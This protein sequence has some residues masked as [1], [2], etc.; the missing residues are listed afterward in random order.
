MTEVIPLRLGT[1]NAYLLRGEDGSV[2]VDAG[3]PG[4]E[5]RLESGLRQAGVQPAQ[6]R[7]LLLTHGHFDHAGAAAYFQRLGVP[8][9]L[10]SADA[11]AM[12]PMTGKG[13]MGKL[14]LAVSGKLG[15]NSGLPAAVKLESLQSLETYGVEAAIVPLPGHTAG[16]VGVLLPDGALIAG[17]TFMNFV[18]PG[19][20]HIAEDFAQM[21]ASLDTLRGRGVTQVYPGHG[22]PFA[23]AF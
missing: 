9:A 3:G 13:L 19:P 22:K 20:A 17:D 15:D 16:S 18:R 5:A 14:L 6:L 8:V 21:L 12:R 2:L 7:L 23:P 10:H 11:G 4:A 1:V